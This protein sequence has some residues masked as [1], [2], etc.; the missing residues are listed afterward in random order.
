MSLLEK[1]TKGWSFRSNTPSFD[2]GDEISVFVTG[3]ED[4]EPVARIGDSKLRV[5]GGSRNL[6]DKRVLLR[7]TAFDDGEHVGE[8]E[9]LETV[10]ES[11]F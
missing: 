4:G 8:A 2:E 1:Y 9:Y 3:V 5:T 6:V 11:A 10:G 7:V